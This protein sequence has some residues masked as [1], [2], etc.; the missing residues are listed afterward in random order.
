MLHFFFHQ[1][2]TYLVRA[3]PVLS[4]DWR[5][6]KAKMDRLHADFISLFYI[7]SNY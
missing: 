7:E 4:P 6:D 3:P 5:L 1:L 2:Q